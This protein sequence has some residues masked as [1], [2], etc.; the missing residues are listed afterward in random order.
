[1]AHGCITEKVRD[2]ICE[3]GKSGKRIIVD[4]RDRIGLYKYVTVKPNE[5]EAARATGF[6]N[7][8]ESVKA[9]EKETC[10]PSIVTCGD[11]GCYVCEDGCA[12]LVPAFIREGEIDFC[13]AGEGI[14]DFPLFFRLLKKYG[15]NFGM[16]LH[17]IY[18][19]AKMPSAIE[20]IRGCA[21]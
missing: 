8:E 4:S 5:I 19:T 1:M 13:G 9:L 2:M 7:E 3:L 14:V 15:C 12:T 21:V 20:F 6:E 11:R 16:T 18:D 17:S 10:R